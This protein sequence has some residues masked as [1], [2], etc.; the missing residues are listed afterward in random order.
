MK[1]LSIMTRTG[2]SRLL[3]A[4]GNRLVGILALKD[5]LEFLS[6]RVETEETWELPDKR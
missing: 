5:M 4:T 6:L 2:A 3:V 1:A